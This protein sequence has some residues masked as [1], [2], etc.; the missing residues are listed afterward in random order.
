MNDLIFEF[1]SDRYWDGSPIR[2]TIRSDIFTDLSQRELACRIIADKIRGEVSHISLFPDEINA[3]L[4]QR[5]F[6]GEHNLSMTFR[7]IVPTN[8]E[9]QAAIVSADTIKPDKT[10][11]A[12]P[13]DGEV[14]E[15][16]SYELDK[17]PW[18]DVVGHGHF[19]KK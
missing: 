1:R 4:V 16:D 10:P 13:N 2:I 17:G 14:D 6:D 9:T 19:V 7:E 15:E 18:G 5:L 12:N 3:S 8:I 11:V